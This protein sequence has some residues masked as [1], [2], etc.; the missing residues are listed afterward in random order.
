MKHLLY[1][2]YLGACTSMLALS[3]TSCDYVD[4]EGGKS[5]NAVY[6]ETP[7]N[8][9]IINFMVEEKGGTAYL[10]P[11]LAN[12]ESNSVDVRVEY[13]ADVLKKFNEENN[14]SYEAL[15]ASAFKMVNEDGKDFSEAADVT[16]NPGGVSARLKIVIDSLSSK[17]YPTNKKYAIPFAITSATGYDV[18]SS[19]KTAILLINRSIITSIGRFVGGGDGI[20]I[21]PVGL[22]QTE[23]WTIQMSAIYSTLTRGNLTTAYLGGVTGAFYTRINNTA[24]IQVKN[25]R[26]GEDTWT[27]LPLSA[28]KWLHITYVYKNKRLSVYVN[29]KIQKTFDTSSIFLTPTTTLTIGNGGYRNDYVREVR[30]WD[31]ALSE[32]EINDYMYLP[33]DP[34][35]PHL[36]TYLPF[37]KE[38]GL[39]D[40]KAPEG[41]NNV[42]TEAKIDFVENVKFPAEELL[43]VK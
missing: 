34:S 37:T 43:I 29:G 15:P 39:K 19:Q 28:G 25:G 26:D 12:M 5:K 20:R 14:T 6:M 30:L 40:L 1:F 3:T 21:S 17:E 13:N 42:V 2:I 4:G 33:M 36:V 27:Q 23:E 8:K 7:N 24:G 16:I 35:T 32:T 41:T 22:K 11:R 9:G 38:A 18:I 10:T 31:K